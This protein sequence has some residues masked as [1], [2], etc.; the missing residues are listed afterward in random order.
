MTNLSRYNFVL[1]VKP[2]MLA[3]SFRN[4]YYVNYMNCLNC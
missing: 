1:V 2:I 3:G 4:L